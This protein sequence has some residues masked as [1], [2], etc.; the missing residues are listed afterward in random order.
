M[1]RTSMGILLGDTAWERLPGLTDNRP[2]ASI[3]FGGRYRMVDFSLSNM[4]HAGVTRIGV[5]SC[6]H[7][8]SLM[9]HIGNGKEWDLSRK[10]GG[11]LLLPPFSGRNNGMYGDNVEALIGIADFIAAGN[12][13]LCMLGESDMVS[14]IN[15]EAA[16]RA[17]EEEKNDITVVYQSLTLSSPHRVFDISGGTVSAVRE[18]KVNETG[19]VA[20][21][22]IFNRVR[23]INIIR[24]AEDHD[25][26]DFELDM[27]VNQQTHASVGA[28]EA[29]G[30]VLLI[31]SLQDYFTAGMSVLNESVRDALFA[32]RPVYTSDSTHMPAKFGQEG[33]VTNSLVS[34]GCEIEGE[35]INCILF[36]GVHIGKGARVKNSI[37]MNDSFIGDHAHVSSVVVDRGARVEPEH[38]LRGREDKVAYLAQNAV[39]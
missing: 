35:V 28:V 2:T 25:F 9:D 4:V 24:E 27:I 32:V 34:S 17:H 38:S 15:L 11:L 31:N 13:E 3:P 5:L 6:H 1:K 23:L 14:N 19:N 18:G 10:H 36:R 16:L 33:S 26:R 12:E 30:T 39:I 21:A 20:V 22:Y 8:R 37:V 29:E 7:Y